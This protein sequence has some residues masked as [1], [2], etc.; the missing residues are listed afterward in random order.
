MSLSG[1]I[2]RYQ[3][4]FR[5]AHQMR[6][7]WLVAAHESPP[8]HVTYDPS[9]SAAKAFPWLPEPRSGHQLNGGEIGMVVFLQL[10]FRPLKMWA[11]TNVCGFW[12]LIIL[13][14]VIDSCL[15]SSH[16]GIPRCYQDYVAPAHPGEHNCS[17]ENVAENI[18]F[19]VMGHCR[20]L[21][22]R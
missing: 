17:P 13:T 1:L 20:F 5:L 7:Q 15:F 4:L 22:V 14:S 19:L 6:L 11:S 18:S 12:I 2:S 10:H 8:V 21:L 3:S 9:S 16:I